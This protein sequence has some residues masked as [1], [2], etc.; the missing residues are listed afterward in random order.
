MKV[1][2][3]PKIDIKIRQGNQDLEEIDIPDHVD[4][5]NTAAKYIE[6]SPG[7]NFSVHFLAS[8]DAAP[9][10]LYQV[11]MSLSIDGEAAGAR[12]FTLHEDSFR[13]SCHRVSGM[14]H[15]RYES[16]AHGASFY[17]F[18]FTDLHTRESGE[19]AWFGRD[20][21]CTDEHGADPVTLRR[22]TDELA[23][24]GEIT[25]NCHWVIVTGSDYKTQTTGRAMSLQRDNIT[26]PEKALK[27]RA[28]SAKAT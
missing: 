24:L 23:C 18:M 1:A 26:V 8:R 22:L 25:V 7:A 10:P 17:R 27:G 21:D 5:P 4:T 3:A 28:V 9:S 2:S 14:F 12:M 20:T 11:E 13:P 19:I 15:G 6:V 16:H